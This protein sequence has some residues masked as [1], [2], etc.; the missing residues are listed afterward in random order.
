MIAASL[1]D[2]ACHQIAPHQANM[3]DVI[4][5]SLRENRSLGFLTWSHT[6]R[7]VQSQK[8]ARGLEFCI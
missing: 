3:P 7:A 5:A 4:G 1:I 2:L 6:N 8:M